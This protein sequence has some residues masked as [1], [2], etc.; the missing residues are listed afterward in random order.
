[1]KSNI[2]LREDVQSLPARVYIGAET[3]SNQ[4]S[5]GLVEAGSLLSDPN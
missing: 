5:L 3:N 2:L 1:M 4:G